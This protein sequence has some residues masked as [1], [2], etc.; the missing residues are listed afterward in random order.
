[1]GFVSADDRLTSDDALDE[2][3]DVYLHTLATGQTVLVTGGS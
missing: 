3:S 1:V 2:E